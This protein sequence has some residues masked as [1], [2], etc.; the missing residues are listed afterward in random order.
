[1]AAALG[2]G[3]HAVGRRDPCEPACGRKRIVAVGG[4]PFEDG[5]LGI[6][7]DG[8]GQGFVIDPQGRAPDGIAVG[9][10]GSSRPDL[11]A[12][13][14]R[15]REVG[16][17]DKALVAICSVPPESATDVLAAQPAMQLGTEEVAAAILEMPTV[18]A[19]EKT[20]G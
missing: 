4:G 5:L 10:L 14:S 6:D 15:F 19:L 3:R 11:I 1:V 16:L 2:E 9:P 7:I 18:Q 12:G 8:L 17:T 13:T 20:L